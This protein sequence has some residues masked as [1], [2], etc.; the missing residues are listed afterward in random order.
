LTI[1]KKPLKDL[2]G[3][4][5]SLHEIPQYIGNYSNNCIA[6]I[7]TTLIVRVCFIYFKNCRDD[8]KNM[9]SD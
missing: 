1:L 2:D 6:M 7:Y 5:S 8:S 4:N 9:H 3:A